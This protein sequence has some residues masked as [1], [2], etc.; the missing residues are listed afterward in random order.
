MRKVVITGG[1]K[2]IGLALTQKFIENGDHVTIIARDFT[3][4]SDFDYRNHP[5]V[6]CISFDLTE[7]EKLPELAEQ[8]QQ[9]DVLI[10]NAGLLQPLTYTDYPDDKRDYSLALNIISPVELTKLLESKLLEASDYKA[11]VV[12][13]ASIAGQIGHPDIWYGIS[14]AGLINA[15]KAFSKA[16]QDKIIVN[17]VAPSPTETDLLASIPEHRQQAF[18][19][20]TI[21]GRFAT[22][23]EVASTMFWLAT[24]SPEY[25]NGEC[26][27]INNGA[28]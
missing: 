15:T 23:E 21:S 20:N 6:K 4:Q 19:K 10:N 22:A 16:F 17:A 13:N 25:I 3:N 14:K 28:R 12:N 24:D 5:D 1:N 26:I 27:N 2:G 7:I 11:R 8:I 9:V 18:L